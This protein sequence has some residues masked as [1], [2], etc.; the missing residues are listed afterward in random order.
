MNYGG[1]Y[2]PDVVGGQHLCGDSVRIWRTVAHFHESVAVGEA[3]PGVVWRSVSVVF[4][5]G[6]KSHGLHC[7]LHGLVQ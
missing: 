2:E 6:R 5:R 3:L 1:L 4:A 7:M